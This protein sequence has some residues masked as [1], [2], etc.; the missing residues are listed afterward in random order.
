MAR[1]RE[2]Q[3][4]PDWQWEAQRRHALRDRVEAAGPQPPRRSLVPVSG[5]LRQTLDNCCPAS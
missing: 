4:N 1:L 2:V 5:D 3:E